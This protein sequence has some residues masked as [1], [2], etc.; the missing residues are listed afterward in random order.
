MHCERVW[1]VSE[2][3]MKRKLQASSDSPRLRDCFLSASEGGLSHQSQCTVLDRNLLDIAFYR[4]WWWNTT[5]T[6]TLLIWLS[7]SCCFSQGKCDLPMKRVLRCLGI[8]T[9]MPASYL[10]HVAMRTYSIWREERINDQFGIV[11]GCGIVRTISTFMPL[12]LRRRCLTSLWMIP[13]TVYL[14]WWQVVSPCT[15][16][17]HIYVTVSGYEILSWVLGDVA[18][19]LHLLTL[20]FAVDEG[21]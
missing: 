12:S 6:I 5:W 4:C 19:H 14:I 16:K 21:L 1:Y 7:L 11:D 13:Y 3:V 9:T 17:A 20:G 10:S 15:D 8:V 18:Q 2:N